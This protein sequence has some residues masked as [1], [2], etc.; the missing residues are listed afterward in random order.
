MNGPVFDKTPCDE[1]KGY[2]DQGIIIVTVRDGETSQNPYRTGGFYVL[3]QEACER[4]FRD[5]DLSGRFLF[6]ED[7]VARRIGLDKH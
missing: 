4:M 3:K 6:I 2:M 5:V 7:S 1:C